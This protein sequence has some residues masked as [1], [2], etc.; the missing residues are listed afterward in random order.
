MS[1]GGVGGDGRRRFRG[2]PRRRCGRR[3]A[4][5]LHYH[6]RD[7]GDAPRFLVRRQG[8]AN[9]LRPRRCSDE[10]LRARCCKR[11]REKDDRRESRTRGSRGKGKQRRWGSETTAPKLCC[12]LTPA[13]SK[14]LE[15]GGLVARD[16]EIFRVS[17]RRGRGIYMVD[18]TWR[19]GH[20][21]LSKI[22]RDTRSVARG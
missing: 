3:G 14:E 9:S 1:D 11:K 2:F 18:E 19:G 22:G 16:R 13:R 15:I 12:D 20:G 8:S 10:Q 17:R 6:A 5:G 7:L 21:F 4:A